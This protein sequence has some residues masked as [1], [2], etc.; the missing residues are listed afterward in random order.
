MWPLRSPNCE[1][2]EEEEKE[3]EERS[4]EGSNDGQVRDDTRNL[5][6]DINRRHGELHAAGFF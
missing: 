2:A 3:E 5:D 4:A 6:A 1:G